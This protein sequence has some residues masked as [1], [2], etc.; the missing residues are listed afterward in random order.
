MKKNILLLL[1]ISTAVNAQ[2]IDTEFI[3]GTWKVTEVLKSPQKPPFSLM[4]DSFKHATFIF[5]EDKSAV[6]ET[7]SPSQFFSMI[8]SII[9]GNTIWKLSNTG[10]TSSIKYEYTHNKDKAMEIAVSTKENETFFTLLS[11]EKTFMLKVEKVKE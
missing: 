2:K 11:E 7:S 5:N 4:T 6:I 9:K 8:T 10:K 1:L 3:Q